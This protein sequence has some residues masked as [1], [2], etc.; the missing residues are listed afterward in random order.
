VDAP[1]ILVR[2]LSLPAPAGPAGWPWQYHS[3]SDRHS[4]VASWGILFDL[5]QQSALL[6]SHLTAGKVTFGVN[7]TMNDWVSYKKKNLDLVICRPADRV[8]RQKYKSFR[9]YGAQWRVQLTPSQQQ[10]LAALPNPVEAPVSAVLTALE[11]K[12]CMTAH[13]KALPRF[14]D[15]LNS[16]HQIVH[17]A[18]SQALS[19]GFAMINAS[20]RFIS[21][22]RNKVPGLP[23]VFTD[24]P[25]PRAATVA[26]E[27]VK[28]LPRR[29]GASTVGYDGLGIVVVDMLNDGKSPVQ[30]VTAPPAPPIGDS[31]H[32][33]NMIGRMANEYDAR[34]HSI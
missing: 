24:H 31:F 12:A 5:M 27:T 1:D 2:T 19:I 18:S 7:H 10:V 23:T 25:Q 29:S 33:D 26:V 34:F 13:S 8:A 28:K 17:G 9:E 16:S 32:Y 21:S 20:T 3:R 14:F 22:D 6:R 11:A 15:E 4:K 30:L